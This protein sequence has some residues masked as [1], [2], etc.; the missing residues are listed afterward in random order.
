MILYRLSCSKQHQFDGWFP[1]SAGYDEQSL[2]G[3]VSCPVCGCHQINKAPMAP[4]VAKKLS[5]EKTAIVSPPSSETP[6]AADKETSPAQ[7]VFMALNKMCREIERNC[8]FVG[9]NF[10]E[11]ARKIEYGEAARRNIYG[12]ASDQEAE[13][14][15]EEGVYFLRMPWIPKGDA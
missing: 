13:A 8:E 10:S 9:D 11:E 6:T 3:L 14:L 12:S 15:K 7:A 1:S 5:P 4:R 2:A